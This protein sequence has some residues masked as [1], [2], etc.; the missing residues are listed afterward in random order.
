MSI[1]IRIREV[2]GLPVAYPVDENAQ[3]FASMVGT[4]TLTLKTIKYI[5]QLGYDVVVQQPE[6]SL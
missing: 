3:V 5:K 1:T 6:L 2:Y 4:R